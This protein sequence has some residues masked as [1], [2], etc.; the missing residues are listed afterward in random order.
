MKSNLFL[1]IDTETGGLG[2]QFSLLTLYIGILNSDFS[3]K[4]EFDFKLKPNDGNYIVCGEA[5]NINKINLVEHDK[6]AITYK[7]SGKIL[8]NYL[9]ST[10]T[11]KPEDLRNKLIPI[12]HNVNGDI[13]Q[14]QD[15][16]INVDNWNQWVSYRT[17]DTGPIGQFLKLCGKLPEN[18]SGSLESYAQYFGIP[19]QSHNAKSDALVTLSV[20][21]NMIKLINL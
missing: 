5:L 3:I 13:R 20:L 16:I 21:Q 12:G 7:E 1:V 9:Y 6:D 14:I 18:L 4:H 15:K 11:E 2:N 19:H 17:L 10:Y 8:G